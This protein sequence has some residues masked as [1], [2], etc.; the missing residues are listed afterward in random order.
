M[1]EYHVKEHDM[2]DYDFFQATLAYG[3]QCGI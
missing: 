1:S 3:K 2:I